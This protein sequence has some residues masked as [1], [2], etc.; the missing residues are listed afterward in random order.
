[1]ILVSR[2]LLDID[3]EWESLVYKGMHVMKKAR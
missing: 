1:M 3:E 2:P